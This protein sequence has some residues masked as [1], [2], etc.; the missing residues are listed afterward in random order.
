MFRTGYLD[1]NFYNYQSLAI[2]TNLNTGFSGNP[3]FSYFI[4]T[5][6]I[7]LLTRIPGL[8]LLL[9]SE[10]LTSCEVTKYR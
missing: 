5:Y 1:L 10:C 6:S 9:N 7:S 3:P 2:Q 4:Y 8:K